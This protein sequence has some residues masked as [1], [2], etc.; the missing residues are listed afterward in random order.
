MKIPV[1]VLLFCLI[2][3]CTPEIHQDAAFV[4]STEDLNAAIAS[5]NNTITNYIA[6]DTTKKCDK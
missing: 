6:A 4:K 3:A 1:V 5:L 2:S